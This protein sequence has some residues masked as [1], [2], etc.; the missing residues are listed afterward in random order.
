MSQIATAQNQ[1]RNLRRQAAARA[2]YTRAKR[3][4][5]AGTALSLAFALLGPVL[6]FLEPSAG[7]LLGALAGIWL[8]VTRLLV[9]P[10]RD[11]AKLAGATAQ[12]AFDCDVLGLPWNPALVRKLSDEEIASRSRKA[13]LVPF[14]D[15]YPTDN[16]ASWPSSVI[17][18]QRANAVWA[19]RLHAGYGWV[20]IGV[21]VAWGVIGV[22]AALLKGA[23]LATYLVAVALP[24]LPALL[25]AVD[26][27]R[28]HFGAAS[29]RRQLEQAI[30]EL[31]DDTSAV[32]T[33]RLR[34][35]QDQLF[36]LRRDAPVVPNWFYKLLAT[37][38]EEDMRYA[39]SQL[40]TAGD[41]E[42][43]DN[44]GGT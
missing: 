22:G 33:D 35:N 31:L 14:A 41:E 34:E 4:Q 20:L 9:Q 27:A 18:C 6:L 30:D 42:T 37:R 2:L 38:F 10:L 26:V 43:H 5:G 29:A 23:T 15:W 8:F 11:R 32:E 16:D 25:D 3:L 39:A 12:E 28:S 40:V 21:A 7:A 24:S 1:N 13:D 19:R 44:A 17:V 36:T